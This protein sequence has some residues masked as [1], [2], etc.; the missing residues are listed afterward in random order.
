MFRGEFCGYLHIDFCRHQLVPF[1]NRIC[2]PT[3]LKGQAGAYRSFGVP[4][5][6]HIKPNF[7]I[8]RLNYKEQPFHSCSGELA[9][10]E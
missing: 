9:L 3:L 2:F 7:C 5:S 8:F 1:A 4:K 10:Q 6:Q